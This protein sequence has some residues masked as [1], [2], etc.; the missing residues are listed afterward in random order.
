MKN[1]LYDELIDKLT[2]I[3]GSP[4]VMSTGVRFRLK[5]AYPIS[6]YH[7]DL[8]PGNV[9]EIAF[10]P[11]IVPNSSDFTGITGRDVHINPRFKW[12]RVGI[13]NIDE[14]NRVVEIIKTKL[15]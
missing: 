9:A 6:V 3:F 12:H 5:S 7:S 8:A 1:K 14:L 13:S 15:V 2:N 11:N 10:N 4:S